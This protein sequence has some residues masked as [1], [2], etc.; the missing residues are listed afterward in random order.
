MRGRRIYWTTLIFTEVMGRVV[1][2]VFSDG[3]ID[4]PFELDFWS[5]IF[6]WESAGYFL[7]P[8]WWSKIE[9]RALTERPDHFLNA[10][11]AKLYLPNSVDSSFTP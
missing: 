4:E 8:G 7:Y 1:N 11:W 10:S 6:D 9:L 2:T 3:L 5:Q